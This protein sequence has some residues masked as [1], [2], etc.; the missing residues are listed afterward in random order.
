M[1]NTRLFIPASFP[2]TPRL[3]TTRQ[4]VLCVHISIWGQMPTNIPY[5]RAGNE[6]A[7]CGGTNKRKS[8]LETRTIDCIFD[9]VMG[10]VKWP[11]PLFLSRFPLP[12][13]VS[14]NHIMFSRQRRTASCCTKI[15]FFGP[16][17][18]PK[19]KRNPCRGSWIWEGVWT[20]GVVYYASHL[21]VRLKVSFAFPLNFSFKKCP[22]RRR[23]RRTKK[24]GVGKR[25][26]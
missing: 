16:K 8:R 1:W 5:I 11:W 22:E 13:I 19:K 26:G 6:E 23:R 14:N 15:C 18:D 17:R 7:R 4:H 10:W 12:H 24:D 25:E 21:L 2:A 3:W 9:M 20:Y